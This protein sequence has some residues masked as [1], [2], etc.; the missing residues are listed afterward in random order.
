[1]AERYSIAIREMPADERPRERFT[2]VGASA[3]S[4]AELLA[5]LMGSGTT[6]RSVLNV[7]DDLIHR[8]GGLKGLMQAGIEEMTQIRGI[9]P[10]R[11][12]QIAAALELGKRHSAVTEDDKPTICTPQDVAHL[13]MPELRD[14]RQ[15]HLKVLMLDTKNRVMKIVHITTGTLDGSMVHPREVFRSAIVAS[16]AAIIAVHNHPSGDPMPS[17]EDRR[18][19]ARLVTVGKEVGIE[20]LDHIIIG[21]NRWVSMKEKGMV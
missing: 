18:V 13:L 4:S 19:T 20:L 14:E 12:V 3:C 8:F 6:G 10:V 15:E 5:I 7:A 1:M 2:R 11:A 9:G 21:H 16:A 17:E